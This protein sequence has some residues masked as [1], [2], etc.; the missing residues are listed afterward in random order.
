MLQEVD[1][2]GFESAAG[3]IRG[4]HDHYLRTPA[5]SDY[6]NNLRASHHCQEQRDE[7]YPGVVK[8]T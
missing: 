8:H 4:G 3:I 6:N 2:S 7:V 5:S 1:R